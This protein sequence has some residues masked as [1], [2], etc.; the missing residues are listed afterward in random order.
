MLKNIEGA[1]F[2]LDGTLVDSIWVWNQIDINY[3]KSKGHS[4]PENLKNQIMHLS[5]SQTAAYFKQKFNLNDP[6]EKIL[7]DWHE[8]AFNHY[9]NNV[10]LKIGVKDFLDK[11]K[12][13]DIKIAL[14]TSNST[15]LLEACL[16]NNKIYDYFDSITTTD[17]VSNG[18]NCPDVYLLAANKLGV[19]P[20]NCLVFED[21]LPAVQGAKAANMKVIAVRDDDSLD[22]KESLIKCADMYIDSFLEL[23]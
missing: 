15:P 12:S 2:D 8:M 7:G 11:L 3:L 1:I 6:I 22:S 9:S 19:N 17:E 5:F 20:K 16:K 10:K 23:I 21:I 4:I 18:K 13:M 14:A